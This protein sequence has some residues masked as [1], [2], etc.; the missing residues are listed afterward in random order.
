MSHRA[1]PARADDD[2]I[3]FA[4]RGLVDDLQDW[5][6]ELD[7][8]VRRYAALRQ[9]LRLRMKRFA[10]RLLVS[11]FFCDSQEGGL[12]SERGGK[13]SAEIDRGLS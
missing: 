5:L 10:Q 4:V 6:T 9:R 1:R 11:R 3:V 8:Y 12:G 2:E 13:Q 7:H